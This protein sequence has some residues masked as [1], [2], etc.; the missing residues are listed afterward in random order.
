[1]DFTVIDATDARGVRNVLSNRRVITGEV[2]VG[3]QGNVPYQ[4]TLERDFLEICDFRRQSA[5]VGAQP[6]RI[7]FREGGRQ[8]RYTPDYLVKYRPLPDGRTRIPLLLEL[9]P[10]EDLRDR[11]EELQPGFK[12]AALLCRERGWRFRVATERTIRTPYLE[13]IKFLRKFLDRPDHDCI[14]QILYEHMKVLQV[15]TPAELLAASFCSHDRRL[16][17]VGILWKLVADGRIRADLG[18]P[19]TMEVP[20]WSMWYERS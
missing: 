8:R 18:R 2:S 11:L 15:S 7:L 4:G 20:I 5:Y 3:D 19:L 16:E 13:N 10:Y 6:L 17:A 9:K 1:M 12:R 14:G